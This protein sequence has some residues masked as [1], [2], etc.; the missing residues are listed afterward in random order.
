MI[1]GGPERR[2]YRR[3]KEPFILEFQIKV[4]SSDAHD[5]DGWATVGAQDLSAGGVLFNSLREVTEGTSLDFKIDYREF[6]DPV[7]CS[8]KVLR[9][10][11]FP[12]A[13]IWGIAA[14]FTDISSEDRRKI[15]MA[16]KEF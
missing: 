11:A 9:I 2:R 5:P 1:Y 3:I 13:H 15:V 16:A 14:E 6:K 12:D 10:D 7:V 8:G 4:K